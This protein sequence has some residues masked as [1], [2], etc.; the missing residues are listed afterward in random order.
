VREL[1]NVVERAV[2][3]SDGDLIRPQHIVLGSPGEIPSGQPSLEGT[4]DETA[5]RWRRAG[6]TARIRGALD[7]SGGDRG[8]AAE[9]LG[10]PLRRLTQRMKELGI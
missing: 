3:L 4:L 8:R 5:E 10:I 7:E 2:I 9:D 6:E 1:R